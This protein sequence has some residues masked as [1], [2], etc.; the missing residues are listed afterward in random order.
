MV[1]VFT[2][3]FPII[4]K[5]QL[6]RCVKVFITQNVQSMYFSIEKAQVQRPVRVQTIIAHLYFPF[7]HYFS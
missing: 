4:R 5:Q 3:V 7:Q 1:P 2:D 6:E